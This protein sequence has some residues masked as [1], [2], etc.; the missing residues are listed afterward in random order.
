MAERAQAHAQKNKQDFDEYIRQTA[1]SQ[2]GEK[3]G[4]VDQLA[5]L[6]D[7]KSSGAITDAEYDQA[8]KKLLA[9]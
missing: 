7:L 1:G 2:G 9:A 4:T 8:K 6:A 5:Q 3:S